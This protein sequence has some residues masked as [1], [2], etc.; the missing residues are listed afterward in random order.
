MTQVRIART[1][2][3]MRRNAL[4]SQRSPS[5]DPTFAARVGDRTDDATLLAWVEAGHHDPQ[6]LVAELHRHLY[7]GGIAEDDWWRHLYDP[8]LVDIRNLPPA[9]LDAKEMLPPADCLPQTKPA[10]RQWL[11]GLM[12]RNGPRR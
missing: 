11:R 7:A 3:R 4:A 5:S 2:E 8:T 12:L 10:L 6:A 9:I 1:E